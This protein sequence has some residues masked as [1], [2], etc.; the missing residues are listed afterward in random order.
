M[1]PKCHYGHYVEV[2]EKGCSKIVYKGFSE[3]KGLR[4][5]GTKSIWEII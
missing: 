2:L 1:D 5:H 4:L 3:K